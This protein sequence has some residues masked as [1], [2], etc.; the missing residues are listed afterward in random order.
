MEHIKK[1]ESKL[2]GVDFI[3]VE[4]YKDGSTGKY[5]VN[6]KDILDNYAV[7]FVFNIYFSLRTIEKILDYVQLNRNKPDDMVITDIDFE[8]R[9]YKSLY[10][11]WD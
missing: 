5:V 7:Y 2:D 4:P 3:L 11:W 10:L 1:L 9:K 8:G 6:E